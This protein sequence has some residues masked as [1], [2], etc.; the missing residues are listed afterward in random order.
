[1]AINKKFSTLRVYYKFL[2]C[3]VTH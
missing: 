3:Y 1:M 2:G